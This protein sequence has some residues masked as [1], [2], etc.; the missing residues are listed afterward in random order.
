MSIEHPRQCEL[1][2]SVDHVVARVRRKFGRLAD[3]NDAAILDDQRAV[4][5]Y[6][7]TRINGDEIV[8][9]ANDE[10][11]HSVTNLLV[12]FLATAVGLI[13][14]D[15]RSRCNAIR[16]RHRQQERGECGNGPS[17]SCSG[18]RCILATDCAGGTNSRSLQRAALLLSASSSH[19]L[20]VPRVHRL[21]RWETSMKLPRRRFL[22]LAA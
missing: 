18:Y 4:A 1:A 6:S 16:P 17:F 15:Q 14:T 7:A 5:D 22:Q 9:V 10:T 11:R 13:S 2:S 20:N 8:D 12:T 21:G 3:P 19:K